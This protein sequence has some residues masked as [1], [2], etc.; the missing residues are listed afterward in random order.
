MRLALAAAAVLLAAGPVSAAVEAQ[1]T[2]RVGGF[3]VMTIDVAA[4]LRDDGYRVRARARSSGL[5]VL[6]TRFDQTATAEGRFTPAGLRPV[7]FRAEGEWQGERRL[8]E[9]V[10]TD[11]TPRIRLEPL[12]VP[13]REPVPANLAQGGID[14]LTALVSIARSV[15]ARGEAGCAMELTIFDGRRLK[16]IALAPAGTGPVPDRP[17]AEA[18]RCRL[19]GRQIAGFWR[20]WDRAEAEKPQFGSVWIAPPYAGAPAMPIRL[21]MGIDWLGT[22]VVSLTRAAPGRHPTR[23]AMTRSRLAGASE[24]RDS[25]WMSPLGPALALAL[26]L[27]GL[28]A[29]TRANEAVFASY[30]VYFSGFRVVELDA[31]LALA[32]DRYRALAR[33]R[34]AGLLAA[35]VRGEQVSEVEGRVTPATALGLSPDRY[36]LEG[37]W[38]DRVRRV[39]LR[40]HGTTPEVLALVPA[41]EEE[42]EPVP[43]ELQRG[44]VDTMSAL[45]ALIARVSASGR[46]DGAAGSVRRAEAQRLHRRHRGRGDARPASLGALRRP[47]AEVPLRGPSGRRLLARGGPRSGP[48]AADGRGVAR[49]ARPGPAG[50]PGAD[51]R[52]DE[53]GHHPRAPDQGGARR[54]GAASAREPELNG[55]HAKQARGRFRDDAMTF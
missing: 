15:A 11:R 24:A 2:A 25:S 54:G 13:E 52:R 43:P 32:A 42:R 37:R 33:L 30:T 39:A 8:V 12:E 44:T 9:I 49:P 6:S 40:W 22:L 38:R 47:G 17:G 34:T 10:L 20:D 14:T 19:E 48:R 45:V 23:G 35:F 1:Y 55:P 46:C 5:A 21:E 4:E 50:D 51:R 29:P 41:N 18:V 26:L 7:L 28:S 27:F 16:R 53:L 3:R 36:A 31:S